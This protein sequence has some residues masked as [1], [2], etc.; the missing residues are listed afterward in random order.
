MTRINLTTDTVKC[1]D[2]GHSAPKAI[3]LS[4]SSFSPP[5]EGYS[6]DGECPECGSENT[7]TV[8]IF[9]HKND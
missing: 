2:C 5:P 1:L 4:A 3:L 9:G 6:Y 8:D 7:S